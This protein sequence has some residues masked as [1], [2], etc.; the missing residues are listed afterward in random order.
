MEIQASETEDAQNCEEI[1]NKMLMLID[2]HNNSQ[3]TATFKYAALEEEKIE[4][5]NT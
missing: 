3:K 2:A 1:K 4:L 5:K